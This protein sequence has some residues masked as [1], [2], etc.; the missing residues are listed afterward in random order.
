MRLGS[1]A[2]GEEHMRALRLFHNKE[3]ERLFGRLEEEVTGEEL[4]KMSFQ[5]LLVT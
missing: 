2:V 5:F 1:L 3:H 4:H